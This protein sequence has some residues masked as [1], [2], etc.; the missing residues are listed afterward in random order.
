MKNY[1]IFISILLFA[2]L[3]CTKES[4]EPPIN[5]QEVKPLFTL[6]GAIE[7]EGVYEEVER[8]DKGGFTYVVFNCNP[9]YSS[10]CWTMEEDENGDDTWTPN[11]PATCTVIC[12]SG[13]EVSRHGNWITNSPND[14]SFN[15]DDGSTF[16][17]D[18]GEGTVV[19]NMADD[20]ILLLYN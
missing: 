14:V 17:W 8:G 16:E 11:E 3:S 7:G 9:P 12:A 1:F 15:C 4:I 2:V 5:N 6:N 19:G 18:G 10:L 20:L 13:D